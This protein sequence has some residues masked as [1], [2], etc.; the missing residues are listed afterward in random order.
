MA[1]MGGLCGMGGLTG[2]GE[3]GM[4]GLAGGSGDCMGA[5]PGARDFGQLV[6]VTDAPARR[7][8]GRLQIFVSG[9]IPFFGMFVTCPCASN[10]AVVMRG[11]DTTRP[12]G[13][14][15]TSGVRREFQAS[16]VCR[17]HLGQPLASGRAG[18]CRMQ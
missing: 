7:A 13:K 16:K 3:K 2:E 9:W 4:G 5:W 11:I 18:V 10:S 14:Y 12:K 15:G 17:H 1:G 8:L 6:W